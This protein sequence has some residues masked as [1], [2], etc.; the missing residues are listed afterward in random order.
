MHVRSCPRRHHVAKTS[1]PVRVVAVMGIALLALA[2]AAPADLPT[3]WPAGGGAAASVAAPKQ[4][5]GGGQVTQNGARHAKP[6]RPAPEAG[7]LLRRG[8]EAFRR[9]AFAEASEDWTQA[10]RAY[11]AAGRRDGRC[12]ALAD[13]AAAEQ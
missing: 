1:R 2:A 4:A 11:A 3:T 10:E 12:D 9:G 5:L 13:L 7:A 8:A 6:L